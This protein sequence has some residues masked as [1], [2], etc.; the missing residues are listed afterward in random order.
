MIAEA[1]RPIVIAGRGAILVRR[2]GGARS[3]GRGEPA[4]CWRRRCSARACSTATRSRSTSP[5]PS[6]AISAASC[7]AESD[8]VIA[9]RRRRSA[10]TRPRAAISIPNAK[11]VRIDTQP[12]G[13]WQGLR[14]A[15]L[16]VR[17]DAKA[18]AEAI[19]ARLQGTR[20]PPPAGAATRSPRRSP[21]TAETQT[22]KPYTPARHAR[23]APG[24]QGARRGGAEGL[25]HRRRRRPLLQ[26]GDDASA[27]PPG[28]QV[29]HPH[30]FRRDRL[31]PARG[32]RRR[33]GAQGDGKVLLV[34]G[35][36]S[37][38]QH[39]QEL[40]TV[41]RQGIKHADLHH[42]RR[43]LWRRDP[44]VPRQ[45][46]RSEARDPRPRRSRRRWRAASA[47]AAPR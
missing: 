29:P 16:H 19:V 23:P 31:R 47:S 6:P 9:R 46:R 3:A 22:T 39:I 13:L 15:D 12:R 32:D 35:D 38:Y 2:Q 18:A 41:R 34:D 11:V 14:T 25:G 42:Q 26:L 33:R 21:P 8:L 24:G 40:E 43:R 1:E 17:A 10:I 28:R 27:R 45:R 44:Q 4:R 37:L 30:R 36:G 20:H 7:F 5:A